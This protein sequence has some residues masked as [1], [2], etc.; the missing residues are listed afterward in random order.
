MICILKTTFL[1]SP[2][3]ILLVFMG[4]AVAG[5]GGMIVAFLIATAMNFGSY[6]FSDKIVPKMC[7]AQEITR[8]IHPAFSGMVE[9]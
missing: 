4:G 9:R 7:N 5:Q 2:M 8:D 1:L 6:W 3:T